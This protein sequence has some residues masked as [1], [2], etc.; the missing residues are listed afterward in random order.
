MVLYS[1]RWKPQCQHS[2]KRWFVWSKE[3]PEFHFG[4]TESEW[5]DIQ[6]SIRRQVSTGNTHVGSVTSNTNEEEVWQWV[7]ASRERITQEETW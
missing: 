7:W 5:L 6:H 2:S 3:H 1:P 4:E